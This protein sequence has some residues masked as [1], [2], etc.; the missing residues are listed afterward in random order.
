MKR[1]GIKM[2][3]LVIGWILSG[4]AG[5]LLTGMIIYILLFHK[6]DKEQKRFICFMRGIR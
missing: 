2:I 5:Y 1:I 4:I 3:E 6:K